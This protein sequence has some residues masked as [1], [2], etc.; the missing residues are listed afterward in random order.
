[1]A[2]NTISFPLRA[3]L[4]MRSENGVINA[5]NLITQWSNRVEVD[6][7]HTNFEGRI[8]FTDNAGEYRQ[9]RRNGTEFPDDAARAISPD[10]TGGDTYWEEISVSG[11][12]SSQVGFSLEQL[13]ILTAAA[14]PADEARFYHWFPTATAFNGSGLNGWFYDVSHIVAPYRAPETGSIDLEALYNAGGILANATGEVQT[15]FTI[16]LDLN[17]LR[18]GTDGNATLE[19]SFVHRTGSPGSYVYNQLTTSTQTF[20][21]AGFRTFEF[22]P[23]AGAFEVGVGETISITL[24][25]L[26]GNQETNITGVRF[27]SISSSWLNP[28]YP[29]PIELTTEQ[30]A[31]IES[32]RRYIN[33]HANA[34]ATGT[35]TWVDLG[36]YQRHDMVVFEDNI[37]A[38]RS[39]TV[40]NTNAN[41]VLIDPPDATA[42]Q[43]RN[44]SDDPTTDPNWVL[45]TQDTTTG[46][47]AIQFNSAIARGDAGRYTFGDPTNG[48]VDVHTLLRSP[49]QQEEST[50]NMDVNGNP[51][52]TI[53]TP[54][55]GLEESTGTET[56]SG[57]ER[58]RRGVA[59]YLSSTAIN[60]TNAARPQV[61]S[62]PLLRDTEIFLGSNN[63]A[64]R[65]TASSDTADLPINVVLGGEFTP[66]AFV[67]TFD[68]NLPVSDTN[69]LFRESQITL[70]RNSGDTV[71]GTPGNALTGLGNAASANVALPLD[72]RDLDALTTVSHVEV[73][74]RTVED[75]V[76]ATEDDQRLEEH[77][78]VQ[79]TFTDT[80]RN[81]FNAHELDIVN[82][83]SYSRTVFNWQQN[84]GVITETSSGNTVFINSL[85]TG[86][87]PTTIINN[88]TDYTWTG[89]RFINASGDV[90][91]GAQ[92][93]AATSLEFIATATTSITPGSPAT[94]GV[95]V[96]Y[97]SHDI[98][99]TL[100]NWTTANNDRANND[101]IRFRE[102]GTIDWRGDVVYTFTGPST[103]DEDPIS[104]TV[105]GETFMIRS[106]RTLSAPA[107]ESVVVIS[108]DPAYLHRFT[109]DHLR[110]ILQGG[111]LVGQANTAP[112]TYRFVIP[113]TNTD[114]FDM[115]DILAPRNYL[116]ES[117]RVTGFTELTNMTYVKGHI[118]GSAYEWDAI[119]VARDSAV[120]SDFDILTRQ[121]IREITATPT[122]IRIGGPNGS[123]AWREETGGITQTGSAVFGVAIGNTSTYTGTTISIPGLD[124]SIVD[125]N[126]YLLDVTASDIP[127]F[128]VGTY[129]AT[130]QQV[131]GPDVELRNIRPVA[132]GVARDPI[133][134]L[135]TGSTTNLALGIFAFTDTTRQL[136]L[137]DVADDQIVM[138]VSAD[139]DIV[140]FSQVPTV[141]GVSLIDRFVAVSDVPPQPSQL[142]ADQIYTIRVTNH[143][144]NNLVTPISIS[145]DGLNASTTTG[146]NTGVPSGGTTEYSFTLNQALVTSIRNNFR[147]RAAL[148]I[149]MRFGSV[150][151][152]V[153]DSVGGGGHAV[154]Y[155]FVSGT[156][157]SFEVDPS[158]G[159][160]YTV[161][162]GAVTPT[163]DEAARGPGDIAVFANDPAQIRGQTFE[164]L[165]AT[166]FI[167]VDSDMPLTAAEVRGGTDYTF[168]VYTRQ[169]QSDADSITNA[170]FLIRIGVSDV[171]V[172][173]TTLT[174]PS[175][176]SAFSADR[177]VVQFNDADE[178]TRLN[179]LGNALISPVLVLPTGGELVAV[180]DETVN[181][182]DAAAIA[183][184]R[185][186][187]LS[188]NK[189]V[190]E[191]ENRIV[192][193][194]NEV[195]GLE[196]G[197]TGQRLDT[198]E[199]RT[200]TIR[201]TTIDELVQ[202]EPVG[203]IAQSW[204][205]TTSNDQFVTVER[206]SFSLPY[207]IRQALDN[208]LTNIYASL[209]GGSYIRTNAA[210][211]NE[212]ETWNGEFVSPYAVL[213]LT[214]QNVTD[215]II[216]IEVA[217][218]SQAGFSHR[219]I[220]PWPVDHMFEYTD[221]N[222]RWF[223][224]NP[225][226]NPT[227][228]SI[229]LTDPI[230][231][232][233]VLEVPLS[234]ADRATL[235][236]AAADIIVA[237]FTNT[238]GVPEERLVTATAG[239]SHSTLAGFVYANL[240]LQDGATNVGPIH[241]QIGSE[242]FIALGGLGGSTHV[243]AN[244]TPTTA[245]LTSLRVDDTVYSIP[246]YTPP[247][248]PFQLS[249]SKTDLFLGTE[250]ATGT[251][252]LVVIP[253]GGGTVG[254]ELN[255]TW[256]E[257][258]TQGT[259]FYFLEGVQ[260]PDFSLTTNL[261]EW[262]AGDGIWTTVDIRDYDEQ[263][264]PALIGQLTAA[265]AVNLIG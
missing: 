195:H 35:T 100:P 31:A 11:G 24:T 187:I 221:L 99:D 17:I 101:I 117:R 159:N 23:R 146:T 87:T 71:G 162:T 127:G 261:R 6:Y 132:L 168:R 124:P 5:D 243:V 126:D 176:V 193:L 196:E 137:V 202:Y 225:L 174:G 194:Q 173:A 237:R 179:G 79:P 50:R 38:L 230:P 86:E 153:L 88:T 253:A 177:F 245:E 248:L 214:G 184:N 58:V 226:T 68:E 169:V 212:T 263:S 157:G 208:H 223:V 114:R 108:V 143:T 136:E 77:R 113:P 105:D 32:Y 259:S 256:T 89:N 30:D 84:D 251:V 74:T 156:D 72:T 103:T 52:I 203:G 7:T 120:G 154:T 13:G 165:L 204:P 83:G 95:L 119:N 51:L 128:P 9:W 182:D 12:G 232:E 60:F 104:L 112:E 213:T 254:Q 115:L 70:T 231:D 25:A 229:V 183:D 66:G 238:D 216:P 133:A 62:R 265:N 37:Y 240:T 118:P 110:W 258:V 178:I 19:L 129:I 69:R 27:S 93:N 158:D 228:S 4:D 98:A 247:V 67:T 220:Y 85:P 172:V 150:T 73:L 215:L 233:D 201:G 217:F 175:R 191:L 161:N 109:D 236:G 56:I 3:E 33:N 222:A 180:H 130:V 257:Y 151:I 1:M 185:S 227:D 260:T 14:L 155:T 134:S 97:L 2:R 209:T 59:D 18:V 200:A 76:R 189:R 55:F 224:E 244:D 57:P 140:D 235:L 181:S 210:G 102:T 48:F 167:M 106:P 96:F 192:A 91:S 171:P 163:G 166:N 44:F 239:R 63:T 92:R 111:T 122:E 234:P 142:V 246:V 206:G 64:L 46:H 199:F 49:W 78:G 205:L 45:L 170:N 218:S 160:P 22:L 36:L 211:T 198:N 116:A 186:E 144:A 80:G 47:P 90:R 149:R 10:A 20:N 262:H 190:D 81:S 53:S 264:E 145:I 65:R 29:L 152:H 249:V 39:E 135:G 207:A 255:L 164:S 82:D 54:G 219:L 40:Y 28:V 250:A 188:E 15:I 61:N 16:D 34:E 148:D 42:I 8:V 241:T 147:D 131:P 139:D 252:S 43:Y 242:I 123:F 125:G 75:Y 94:K 197:G 21:A 26:T 121:A 107:A 141:N 41:G 138:H